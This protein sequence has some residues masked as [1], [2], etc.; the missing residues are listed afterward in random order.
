MA[1]IKFPTNVPVVVALKYARGKRVQSQFGGDETYYSTVDGRE[2]YAKEA[3]EKRITQLGP[4]PGEPFSICYRELGDGR[5][6]WQVENIEDRR[7]ESLPQAAVTPAVQNHSNVPASPNPTANGNSPASKLIA[8]ALIASIDGL[9]IAREYAI[10]KGIEVQLTLD[11]NA[12]DV[13]CLA[14]GTLIQYFKTQPQT[15]APEPGWTQ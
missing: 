5:N 3:L 1:K 9:L 8:S 2:F 4:R 10:S 14:S 13:R 15:Q 6:Q 11:F 7:P 12:E